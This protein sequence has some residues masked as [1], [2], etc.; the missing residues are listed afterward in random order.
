MAC[1]AA[2]EGATPGSNVTVGRPVNGSIFPGAVYSGISIAANEKVGATIAP[3]A[4]CAAD[5][6]VCA[7]PVTLLA[8]AWALSISDETDI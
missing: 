8:N 7:R 5:E 1:S 6:A 3:S 4:D 2:G